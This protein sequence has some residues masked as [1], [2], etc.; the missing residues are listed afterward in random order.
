MLSFAAIQDSWCQA[1]VIPEGLNNNNNN[2]NDDDDVSITST[3]LPTAAAAVVAPT[4]PNTTP[5]HLTIPNNTTTPSLLQP[6]PAVDSGAG[7]RSP[8][9]QEEDDEEED[10]HHLSDVDLA[11]VVGEGEEE[12]DDEEEV[13]NPARL[14][15]AE[16]QM[17]ERYKRQEREER[18]E[19]ERELKAHQL[20]LVRHQEELRLRE[21][22]LQQTQ[23]LMQQKGG[24]GGLG[25][26]G[27]HHSPGSGSNSSGGGGGGM[28]SR[29]SSGSGNGGG[30]NNSNNNSG[31]GNGHGLSLSHH[32]HHNNNNSSSNNNNNSSHHHHH[33]TLN[34]GGGGL[35]LGVGGL[36]GLGGP[37]GTGGGPRLSADELRAHMQAAQLAALGGFPSVMSPHHPLALSPH[38]SPRDAL[39]GLHPLRAAALLPPAPHGPFAT[40]AG[41]G[42]GGGGGGGV[43][44]LP[45]SSLP[46][47]FIP[48]P[49]SQA[50]SGG[51]GGGGGGGGNGNGNGNN[52]GNNGNG[53][54]SNPPGSQ[55]SSPEPGNG[56]SRSHHWTF[57]EQFKQLYELSDDPQRKEFLDDLF[58]FMQKRGSPVNR[59]PI[60]AK[61]TLDLYEL[62]RLVVSKGGLVE[63]INKKLWREITKGLNLPSS[64]T[65][66]A[67]TLR[68]QYMK[69]LYPYECEKLKLSNPTELQAAIDGNRR[70]GRRSSYGY[71]LSPGPTLVPSTHPLN[72]SLINGK[73][74]RGSPGTEQWTNGLCAADFWGRPQGMETWRAPSPVLDLSNK[75]SVSAAAAAAA[76]AAAHNSRVP[77]PH[78]PHPL[79]HSTTTAAALPPPTLDLKPNPQIDD[80]DSLPPTPHPPAPPRGMTERDA[81]AMEAASRAMEEATRKMEASHHRPSPRSTPLG[82]DNGGSP[83]RKRLLTEED[84][85]LAHAAGMPSA[86]LKITSR[87]DGRSEVDGSLVVTMEVNGIMYQGV[88]FAANHSSRRM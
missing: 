52:G 49:P 78:H 25:L 32:H 22:E 59:I 86:H 68:T 39:N 14:D 33:H 65:S 77:P 5:N 42:G 58:A 88:L 45:P 35:G 81:L 87:N 62:F 31:S 56:D 83:P 70:E 28:G 40:G 43:P 15:E 26:G 55:R 63:V 2:N 27:G 82:G 66:A 80:D 47:K 54:N 50:P 41:G 67:F 20:E 44:P 10:N 74:G 12:D 34:G 36:G 48:R 3:S 4:T 13:I 6:P 24:G 75:T 11:G 23:D 72:G 19:I 18:E 84:R 69:Y 9:A 57:E 61:Q 1:V 7:S 17:Y 53:N 64:I 8:V 21:K 73:M 37:V 51:G 38:L 79:H 60:M 16:R 30:S 85:L 76:W 71:D 46:D 29:P